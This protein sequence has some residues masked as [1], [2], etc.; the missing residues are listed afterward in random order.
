MQTREHNWIDT[1]TG[2]VRYSF[3]I[4]KDNRWWNPMKNGKP[5]LFDTPE[6]RDAARKEARHD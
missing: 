6:E 2:K 3:Q 4:K 1:N 5:M